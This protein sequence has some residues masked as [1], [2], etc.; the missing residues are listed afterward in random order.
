MPAATLVQLDK[1]RC[2]EPLPNLVCQPKQENKTYFSKIS[3]NLAMR[4]KKKFLLGSRMPHFLF[5]TAVDYLTLRAKE[6]LFIKW[7]QSSFG[8]S[9][10]R[11][12]PTCSYHTSPKQFNCGSH[13]KM[14]PM[15]DSHTTLSHG[16]PNHP[17]WGKDKSAS[18]LEVKNC[19]ILECC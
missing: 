10:L 7:P 13:A 1:Y 3:R 2:Q 19:I 9:Q 15:T 6:L 12:G 16:T 8:S 5:F 17:L 18:I 14:A 4:T 11:N